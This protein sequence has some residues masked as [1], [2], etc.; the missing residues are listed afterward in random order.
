MRLAAESMKT[1]ELGRALDALGVNRT[2]ALTREDLIDLYV[3]SA[4]RHVKPT[5]RPAAR[6][7][8]GNGRGAPASFYDQE[9]P[10]SWVTAFFILF[11]GVVIGSKFG[12]GGA[13]GGSGGDEAVDTSVGLGFETHVAAGEVREARTHAQFEGIMAHHRSV[14]GVPVIVDFT[15]KTCGPCRMIAPIYKALAHEYAGRA[16]FVKVDVNR[17]HE[18]S[19]RSQVSAMPT[20]HFYLGKKMV[21]R[22]AGADRNG[23][24]ETVRK[25]VAA[26]E[27]KHGATFVGRE[28]TAASLR[29]F[30]AAHD[31]P[32]AAGAGEVLEG[33]AKKAGGVTPT[34]TI[35]RMLKKKY[36]GAAVAVTDRPSREAVAAQTAAAAAEE[37]LEAAEEIAAEEDAKLLWTWEQLAASQRQRG[38][39]G[40]GG[41]GGAD[42]S[43]LIIGGGPAGLAAAIYAARAGL[44]PVVVAPAVGGQLL[45]KGVEVENM[46][47]VVGKDATGRGVV[48]VMRRQAAS[49]GARMVD[50]SVASIDVASGPPFTAVLDVR[51]ADDGEGAQ[52]A[53]ITASALIVATG[54]DAKW[55]GVPGEVSRAGGRARSARERAERCSFRNQLTFHANHAHNLTRSP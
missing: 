2:A 48:V 26:A 8:A 13:A 34:L 6:A 39:G 51:A 28:V 22:F 3:R 41:A 55:L 40:A 50:A 35:V 36:G 7:A 32:K 19:Q 24:A 5:A 43:L 44:N 31:A 12:G 25:L 54:A 52:Q 9:N 49:F 37:A 23:L 45:G 16:A 42:E 18:T 14:T 10:M 53:R 30:Y 4:K 46:P 27:Q 29:A 11:V 47:G 15:S 38:A 17:N 20:F 1:G 21:H 33:M